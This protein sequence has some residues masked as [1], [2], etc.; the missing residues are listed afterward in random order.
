VASSY[1]SRHLRKETWHA[2]KNPEGRWRKYSY[3][4]ILARDKT[5]LDL[6][7]LKDKSL[8]ERPRRRHR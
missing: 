5:S 8:A 7:W 2:E 1:R 6:F 3:A 4:D